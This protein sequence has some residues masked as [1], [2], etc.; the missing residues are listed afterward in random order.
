M[1]PAVSHGEGLGRRMLGGAGALSLTPY[2]VDVAATIPVVSHR[3][4]DGGRLIVVC[5]AADA[6]FYGDAEVRVDGVKK[7]PELAADITVA[8]LHALGRVEW[9]P[10]HDD[11]VDAD[12]SLAGLGFHPSTTGSYAL[13]VVELDRAYLHGPCGVVKLP[14]DELHPHPGDVELASREF[15]ARDEVGRL[16]QDQLRQLLSD[17]LVGLVDGFR[18]SEFELDPSAALHAGEAL[19]DEVWVSDIDV[20]GLMLS[21]IYGARLT[22]VFI[23]FPEEIR[24]FS[25]L[26]GAVSALAATASARHASPRI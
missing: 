16:S 14:V 24:E 15:D 9:L 26:V 1:D 13:G 23:D 6:Q 22:S 17:A 21:T 25:D 12:A 10:I 18:C 5:P 4:S 11:S 7:A 8:G 2:R 20:A 19:G 3:L